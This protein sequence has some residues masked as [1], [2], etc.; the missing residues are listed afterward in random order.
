[1]DIDKEMAERLIKVRE[2]RGVKQAKFALDIG[3]KRST[4]AGLEGGKARISD[5]NIQTICSACNVNEDWFRTGLG[6]MF[7]IPQGGPNIEDENQ[8]LAMFRR[9][10]AE[11]R[12]VVL[13]KVRELLA[14]DGEPW[15]P[16]SEG[17][18]D[19]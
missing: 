16:D 8:L 14:I 18:N 3:I 13:R 7:T 2:A 10:T 12:A 9:L 4:L 15:T 6:E 5:R 1:M 11:M 17:K 19:K